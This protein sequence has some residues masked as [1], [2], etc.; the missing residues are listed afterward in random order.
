MV[1]KDIN[2]DKII[3]VPIVN[4]LPGYDGTATDDAAYITS[5][6]RY[7]TQT[8]TFVRVM[9]MVLNYS[10]GYWFL[11]P[12]I[13]RG[14]ITTKNRYGNPHH[15]I[16]RVGYDKKNPAGALG[17]ALLK[18]QVFSSKEW[19]EGTGTSGFLNC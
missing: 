11:I 16:L 8:N 13:W 1:S 6:H 17:A 18:I 3:E 10:D 14:K 12:D 2:G 19:E 9:S 5:W 4:L 7:D 15:Y